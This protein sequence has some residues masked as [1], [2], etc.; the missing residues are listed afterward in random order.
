ML[1]M[2][3][4]CGSGDKDS[5]RWR[6]D[7]ISASRDMHV[8]AIA[9]VSA[10]EGWALATEKRKDGSVHHPLLRR[11][12][13]DWRRAQLPSRLLSEV[14]MEE[15][16]LAAAHLEASGP[17]NVW[18]FAEERALRWDGGQWRGT[19]VE[20]IARDIAVLAPDDVWA[21]DASTPD[22]VAHHWDG[23]RW[24]DHPL[25]LSYTDSL[26]ASGPDDVW[27]VGSHH[28]SR[29]DGS[30]PAAVHFDGKKWRS[31]PMPE[32]R[33][34]E[35]KPEEESWLSEIVALSPDDAWAF[36]AHSYTPDSSSDR[37]DT[38]IAL[39]WDGSRWQKAPKALADPGKDLLPNSHIMAT[40]DGAGGFVLNSLFGSEQHHTAKGVLRVI[41]D[42]EPVAGRSGDTEDDP[43]QHFELYDLQRVPGTREVWAAGAVGVPPLHPEAA[44]TR[45]VVA[46]Y[47]TDG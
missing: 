40:G 36:G 11:E 18:L 30:R 27:A 6:L 26:S 33:F 45:G 16:D 13:A 2:A 47:S 39:R 24:S 23:K 8:H 22:P 17:D 1:L 29:G 34:P 42:P 3:T 44:F 5:T 41:K 4:G 15:S 9:A 35:P 25:P 43:P 28:D 19:S 20:F 7:Y 14:G 46:S 31:V 10:D 38:P 12:G 21:L 37:R 32:Y